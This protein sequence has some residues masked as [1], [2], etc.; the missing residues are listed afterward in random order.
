MQPR[1]GLS[2]DF[3]MYHILLYHQLP[4]LCTRFGSSRQDECG[5]A[6]FDLLPQTE[7]RS[8]IH[9]LVHST[10]WEEQDGQVQ[11]LFQQFQ[12]DCAYLD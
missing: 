2:L 1:E 5:L 4:L 8:P 3:G 6:D 9:V 11:H 7:L 10:W 12:S